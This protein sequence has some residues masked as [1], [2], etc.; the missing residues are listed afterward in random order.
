M[1]IIALLTFILLIPHVQGALV[2]GT[3]YDFDLNPAYDAVVTVDTIP[4][5]TIVAKNGT[6]S[7]N[8]RS[9]S[10]LL[11]ATHQSGAHS[12]TARQ[13]ITIQDAGIYVLDMI[14]FP[15]FSEEYEILN[16]DFEPTEPYTDEQEGRWLLYMAISSVVA[17]LAIVILLMLRQT[18]GIEP[19]DSLADDVLAFIRQEGGRVT[20]KD[21]RKKFPLSEA[22]IS[23]VVSELESRDLVKRIKKGRA[24]IVVLQE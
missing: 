12:S 11:E 24:N 6:Y 15:D 8:L 22:K 3:V 18:N 1:R 5:Q 23:L 19:S 20:Q 17:L 14:L 2:H 10:Y 21:I 4:K 13:N 16:E 7:F 9:G